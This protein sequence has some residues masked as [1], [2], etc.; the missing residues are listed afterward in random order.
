ML[1]LTHLLDEEQLSAGQLRHRLRLLDRVAERAG[2][3]PPGS[4]RVVRLF[5]RGLYQSAA[6]GSNHNREPLYLEDVMCILDGIAA[7]RTSQ[8]Q[9][10]ALVLLANATGLT[11]RSLQVLTWND[12]RIRRNRIQV[13]SPRRGASHGP[14]GRLDIAVD[15]QPATVQAMTA[16][17]AMVGPGA[18]AVFGNTAADEVA[19][20]PRLR[21]VLEGVPARSSAHWSWSL[22]SPVEERDLMPLLQS[23]LW[24]LP[25]ASPP[26]RPTSCAVHTSR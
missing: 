23:L 7:D 22:A 18:R 14:S 11:L 16:L 17:R 20:M 24:P 8:Q 5:M 12:V 4:S 13:S 21:R 6:L 3:Q 10:V 25:P 9:N 19:S 2:E 26:S 1:Y 15:K